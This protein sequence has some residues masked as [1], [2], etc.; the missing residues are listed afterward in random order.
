M[1]GIADSSRDVSGRRDLWQERRK[2]RISIPLMS[3]LQSPL[4]KY[5]LYT[6]YVRAIDCCVFMDFN[7]LDLLSLFYLVSTRAVIFNH[8]S[9][10]ILP[11]GLFVTKH[12]LWDWQSCLK[13]ALDLFRYDIHSRLFARQNT[14][15]VRIRHLPYNLFNYYKIKINAVKSVCTLTRL[16]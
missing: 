16:T 14:N 1:L 15:W 11:G 13:L 9:F 12:V 2:E 3:D 10:F 7:L 8:N 6:G 4:F 5:L